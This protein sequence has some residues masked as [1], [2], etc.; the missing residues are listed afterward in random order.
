MHQFVRGLVYR[1]Q[2]EGEMPVNFLHAS[3][4]ECDTLQLG[5]QFYMPVKNPFDG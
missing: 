3:D 1:I 4:Q 2:E 5:N